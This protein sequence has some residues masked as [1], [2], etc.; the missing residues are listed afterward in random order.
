MTEP[1]SEN[2]PLPSLVSASEIAS[3]VWCPEAWRLE[4]GLKREP[5]NLQALKR[6]EQHHEQLAQVEQVSD[7]STWVGIAVVAAAGAFL[8]GSLIR[9]VFLP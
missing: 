8:L 5:S 2:D 6:G 3:W 1:P 4:K 9:W 7:A